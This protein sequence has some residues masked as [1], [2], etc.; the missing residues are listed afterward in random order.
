MRKRKCRFWP[1]GV[2]LIFLVIAGLTGAGPIYAEDHDKRLLVRSLGGSIY[3]PAYSHIHTDPRSR[4]PLASTLVIHNIDPSRAITLL[5]ITFHDRDGKAVRSYL[6]N[7]IVLKPFAS[8]NVTV[9]IRED[10]GGIGSNFLV[11]WE[12]DQQALSPLAEAI[13]IGGHGTQGISFKSRGISIS[14]R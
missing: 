2:A 11:E 9:D 10:T 14:R 6:N 12:V 13:M 1:S 7:P 4:Y 5:R 8:T 3:V